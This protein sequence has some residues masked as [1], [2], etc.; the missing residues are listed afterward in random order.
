VRA[1]LLR[2]QTVFLAKPFSVE[3]LLRAVERVLAVRGVA[4]AGG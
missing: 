3:E 1:E 4:R 2:S